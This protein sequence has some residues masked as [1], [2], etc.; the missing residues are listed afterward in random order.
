MLN[1]YQ[2]GINKEQKITKPEY[3][4]ISQ[5]LL[6]DNI[7]DNI[8]N[9]VE[10]MKGLKLN[11]KWYATNSFNFKHNG[12]IIFRLCLSN[13]VNNVTIFQ[14]MV[15]KNDLDDTLLSL[16]DDMR[17]FYFNNLRY[18]RHCNPKHGNGK[19]HKILD[20]EFYICAEPEMYFHNPSIYQIDMIKKFVDIR[21]NNIKFY[22]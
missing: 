17:E 5:K 2:D 15:E 11:P 12:K 6:T 3:Y 9:L 14:T 13:T 20:K 10:Y 22:K 4:E 16:T 18:C 21:M 19:A 7:Y 1:T 8:N